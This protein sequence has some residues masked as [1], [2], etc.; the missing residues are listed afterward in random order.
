MIVSFVLIISNLVQSE[1]VIGNW[2]VETTVTGIGLELYNLAED[3][4]ETNNLIDSHAAKAKELEAKWLVWAK[5]V[6]SALIIA[7]LK[8]IQL[9]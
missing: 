5:R 6:K 9:R 8:K 3:R 7:M 2:C 4:C 1:R